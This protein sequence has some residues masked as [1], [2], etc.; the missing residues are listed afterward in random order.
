MA[1][2]LN[3]QRTNME[4]KKMRKNWY[5]M[6]IALV[7]S[8]LLIGVFSAQAAPVVDTDNDGKATAIR[9]LLF[10]GTRYNVDFVI[11]TWPDI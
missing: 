11:G 6:T 8:L 2:E 5:K 10:D 1:I 3:N 9:N 4:G 7:A